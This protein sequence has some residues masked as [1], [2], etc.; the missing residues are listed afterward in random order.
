MP[1]FRPDAASSMGPMWSRVVPGYV[2]DSS[3]IRWPAR[4]WGAID[5]VAAVM[6][7]R[8]GSRFSVS[9]V[10]THTITS[11]QAATSA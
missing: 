2:V 10:G 1:A 4:R 8:S 3:T 5:S 7:E 11:S 6:N 9:G